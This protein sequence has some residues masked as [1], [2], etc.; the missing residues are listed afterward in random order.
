M[1]EKNLINLALNETKNL[2]KIDFK[3]DLYDEKKKSY[4]EFYI[5][6]NKKQEELNEI[7]KLIFEFD[8]K[9]QVF[10]NQIDAYNRTVKSVENLIEDLAYLE[11]K[12]QVLKDYSSY[13]FSYLKPRLEDIASEYFSTM[14]DFK[15]SRI[16]I[17]SEYNIKIDS[18]I[19]DLY[20]G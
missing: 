13:L 20:S 15:Y 3:Q 7:N 6:F 5:G 18:R 19:L 8:K 11:V 2:E 14:T 1:E 12:K 16:E 9:I 4:D 10:V 17:D